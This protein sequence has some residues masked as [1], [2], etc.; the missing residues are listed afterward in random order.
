ME[1]KRFESFPPKLINVTVKNN[2]NVNAK[3]NLL[4]NSFIFISFILELF[5]ILN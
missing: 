5:L 4:D 3:N 2:A 1:I